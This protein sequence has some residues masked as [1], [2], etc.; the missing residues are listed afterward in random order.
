ML[1]LLIGLFRIS[2]WCSGLF[3]R[4]GLFS[5]LFLV[6]MSSK[7]YCSCTSPTR[8]RLTSK[9]NHGLRLRGGDYEQKSQ[10]AQLIRECGG[11]AMQKVT[12]GPDFGINRP[13]MR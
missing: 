12:L 4:G 13:P 5:L 11:M 10:A 1:R 9:L 6:S 2:N 3:V 7:Y 8:P